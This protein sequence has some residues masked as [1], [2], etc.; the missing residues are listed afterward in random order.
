M[1]RGHLDY[2]DGRRFVT[3]EGIEVD[4]SVPYGGIACVACALWPSEEGHDPCIA[5]LPGVRNA[6]C[7]HGTGLPYVEFLDGTT[8]RGQ[9]ALDHFASQG[10]DAPALHEVA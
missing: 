6:C 9:E 8:L 4:S 5:S 10:R 3:E 7:G 1:T 2:W